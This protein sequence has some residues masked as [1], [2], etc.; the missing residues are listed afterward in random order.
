[1]SK[2]GMLMDFPEIKKTKITSYEKSKVSVIG[3]TEKQK[4]MDNSD[5]FLQELHRR[6]VRRSKI[7]IN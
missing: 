6:N 5:K 7:N 2:E 4:M 1:M 3:D